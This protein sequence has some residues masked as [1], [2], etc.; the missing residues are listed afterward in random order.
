MTHKCR[1]HCSS[2]YFQELAQWN[3]GTLTGH[4]EKLPCVMISNDF[5]EAAASPLA[6][7]PCPLPLPP[8][9]GANDRNRCEHTQ[10]LSTFQY[11]K[12][13]FFFCIFAILEQIKVSPWYICQSWLLIE[14]NSHPIYNNKVWN[15]DQY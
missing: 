9:E 6:P 8:P 14:E 3:S 15:T 7:P 12:N 1:W 10:M 2:E 4:Y 5:Q 13:S 11:L